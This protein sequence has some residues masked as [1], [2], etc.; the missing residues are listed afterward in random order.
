[1]PLRIYS[2]VANVIQRLPYSFFFFLFCFD[3][4][5]LI[6]T[7]IFASPE[8]IFKMIKLYK[9]IRAHKNTT[10]DYHCPREIDG[11]GFHILFRVLPRPFEITECRGASLPSSINGGIKADTRSIR[12]PKHLI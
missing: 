3:S 12:P 1:M 9:Y 6:E 8:K 4:T 10:A 11:L 7:T 5:E 2:L